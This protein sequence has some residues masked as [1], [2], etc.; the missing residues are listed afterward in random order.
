MSHLAENGLLI[1]KLPVGSFVIMSVNSVAKLHGT[2][3]VVLVQFQT[4]ILTLNIWLIAVN[5][6]TCFLG[7]W[8]E[9]W[10]HGDA[11]GI[12]MVIKFDQKLLEGTWM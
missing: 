12:L 2:Y 7:S 4:S 5:F 1:V 3:F 10:A 11:L 9:L 8:L 6:R